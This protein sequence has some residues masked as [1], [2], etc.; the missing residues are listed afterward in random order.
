MRDINKRNEVA[1]KLSQDL[2]DAILPITF[3]EDKDWEEI[4]QDLRGLM[5]E[6]SGYI[7]D[8]MCYGRNYVTPIAEVRSRVR[9]YEIYVKLMK[10]GG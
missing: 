1:L 6:C 2:H 4:Q 10:R 8:W 9:V 5:I 7:D 3:G